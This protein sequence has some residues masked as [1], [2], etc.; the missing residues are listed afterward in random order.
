[1]TASDISRNDPCPC[2][3]GK[4]FKHCCLGK[5]RATPAEPNSSRKVLMT[6]VIG[7]MMLAGAWAWKSVRTSDSVYAPIAT[8]P[9]TPSTGTGGRTPAPYEYDAV[10]NRYWH[11][12]HG[13]WHDGPPP[14]Q[15][16]Q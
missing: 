6:V 11:E 8:P 14:P 2:G 9:S 10:N 15:P 16:Q 1:M 4:K 12:G 7:V 13:H 3:S 5:R